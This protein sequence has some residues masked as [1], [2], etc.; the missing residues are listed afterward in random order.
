[1]MLELRCGDLGVAVEVK[2]DLF[3]L[4]LVKEKEGNCIATSGYTISTI[5]RHMPW[6][7]CNCMHV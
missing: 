3:K 6:C 7:Y 1:M 4:G 5:T 2:F